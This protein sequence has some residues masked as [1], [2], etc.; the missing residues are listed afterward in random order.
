MIKVIHALQG[1][2]GLYVFILTW[3]YTAVLKKISL[4]S[5]DQ[6]NIS[7]KKKYEDISCTSSI[8]SLGPYRCSYYMYLIVT[9]LAQLVECLIESGRSRVPR[10]R[11]LLTKND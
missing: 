3:A 11:P 4:H 6:N 2:Y 7:T 8:H 10:A 9:G 1:F 5:K